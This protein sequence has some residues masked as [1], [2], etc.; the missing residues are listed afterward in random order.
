MNVARQNEKKRD[1]VMVKRRFGPQRQR[2]LFEELAL[3]VLDDLFRVA[4]RL[5]RDPSRA[6]DLLQDALLTAFRKFS[7]LKETGSFRAWASSI[8]R[9]TFLNQRRR[10]DVAL[11]MEDALAQDSGGLTEAGPGPDE[12]L[13]A[14]RLAKEVKAALD[15]LPEEQ[16]LAVFLID[17]QE[18]T[19]AEAAE[20]LDAPPGTVASRVARGRAV[21][22]AR[23][24]H[25]AQ[26]RGWT[27]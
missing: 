3:P 25:L 27:R 4:W 2:R 12:R 14:R 10:R 19:Y 15:A 11:P 20:A 23:L 26:E 21:L 18:F 9:H 8:V 17:F 16:R 1:F 6:S 7:Q 13:V 24:S 5:E 22:R